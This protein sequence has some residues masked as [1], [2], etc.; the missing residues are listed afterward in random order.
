MTITNAFAS[1]AVRDLGT[2]SQWYEKILGPGSN[3][4]PEVMEWQFER[5]GALQ[6]YS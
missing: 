6:V 2:S 4:M 3:P 5:G 1:L